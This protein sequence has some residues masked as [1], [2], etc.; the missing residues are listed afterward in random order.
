[1]ELL[2]RKISASVY[3]YL[4]ASHFLYFDIADSTSINRRF[5]GEYTAAEAELNTLFS[6]TTEG[7]E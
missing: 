3:E 7:G 4:A 6:S 5:G 1:M 2:K